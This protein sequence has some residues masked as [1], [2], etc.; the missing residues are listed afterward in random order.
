MLLLAGLTKLLDSAGF[1]VVATAGDATALL[2][3]VEREQPDVVIAD[4]RMP[5]E[6]HRRGHPGRAGHPRPVAGHRDP[7]AVPVRGGAVR[8]RPAVGQH[9]RR[10]LPAQGPGGR[11]GRVP[12]RAAP[13][14][15]GRHRAGPGGGRP[16]AGPPGRRPA[17]R[18]DPAGTRRAGAD[19][20]GPVQRR[21]R[22]GPGDHRQRG[23]QAHQLDLRQARACTRATSAT[24]GCWRCCATSA[25]PG[26]RPAVVRRRRSLPARAVRRRPGLGRDLPTGAGRTA[27]RPEDQPLDVVHLSPGRRARVQPRPSA[28]RSPPWPRPAPTSAI[29]CSDRGCARARRPSPPSPAAPPTESSARSTR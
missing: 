28:T 26:E 25:R 27:G 6:P 9:P 29:R 15:G 23:Q 16:A 4:V 12:R 19:G 11:R 21:D 7:G 2:A 10:R 14:G 24:G 22:R 5:P 8:G 17:G 3:A 1:E 20:R 13:G 18:P